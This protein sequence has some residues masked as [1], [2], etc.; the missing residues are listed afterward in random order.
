MEFF[1]SVKLCPTLPFHTV[2][3][4]AV[5]YSLYAYKNNWLSTTFYLQ[6]WPAKMAGGCVLYI[7]IQQSPCRCNRWKSHYVNNDSV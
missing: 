6:K 4:T 5:V 1:F 3:T 2:D 7:I